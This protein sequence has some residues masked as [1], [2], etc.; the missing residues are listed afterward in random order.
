VPCSI[1]TSR[2]RAEN[3]PRIRFPAYPVV[4]PLCCSTRPAFDSGMKASAV[5]TRSL[6]GA[7]GA[8][9]GDSGWGLKGR[10]R[11]CT[12]CLR[13]LRREGTRTLYRV[14]FV[15]A[16]QVGDGRRWVHGGSGRAPGEIRGRVLDRGRRG[17]NNTELK[18]GTERPWVGGANGQVRRYSQKG[19]RGLATVQNGMEDSSRCDTCLI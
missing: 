14:R 9:L 16:S 2:I 18:P 15:G 11:I 7:F 19:T 6:R 1:R 10:S 12:D 4:P 13:S 17:W 8:F 5:P 3:R